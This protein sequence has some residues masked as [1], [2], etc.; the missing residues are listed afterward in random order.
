MNQLLT[1]F[2]YLMKV[3]FRSHADKEGSRPLQKQKEAQGMLRKLEETKCWDILWL[4]K[5]LMKFSYGPQALHFLTA[6]WYLCLQS[7]RS[8]LDHEVS[9]T[10]FRVNPGSLVASPDF[11]AKLEEGVEGWLPLLCRENE[12]NG[13]LWRHSV[14]Q[15][16]TERHF[17]FRCSMHLLHHPEQKGNCSGTC[18]L[19][20]S[21]TVYRP[22]CELL[23]GVLM[24]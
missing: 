19:H 22:V 11:C 18:I 4:S 15:E 13:N 6:A 17:I 9:S 2:E 1:V 24:G 20:V 21:T 3:I 10:S 12:G 8:R 7:R 23:T 14:C 16:D 5:C